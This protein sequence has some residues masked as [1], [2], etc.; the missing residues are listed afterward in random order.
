M[1]K[2]LTPALAF[3]LGAMLVAYAGQSIVADKA[4]I[5]GKVY[6]STHVGGSTKSVVGPSSAVDSHCAAFDGTT[7]ALIKDGGVCG[8]GSTGAAETHTANNSSA[9]LDFTTCVDG[10]VASYRFEIRGLTFATSTANLQMRVLTTGSFTPDTGSNYEWTQLGF[11]TG[12]SPSNGAGSAVAFNTL[13][14]SVGTTAGFSVDVYHL[15]WH[16]LAS[17]SLRK[18]YTGQTSYENSAPAHLDAGVG[19]D[20]LTTGTADTGIR[21][22][23]D[24]GNLVAGTIA[25]YRDPD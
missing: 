18:H 17:T 19:G 7:G 1:K 14:I 2:Y 3:L 21:F 8:G 5:G 4:T 23:S 10:S 13:A 25:C 20:W 11:T 15:I 6:D 12:N 16:N 22:F 9:I 24:N